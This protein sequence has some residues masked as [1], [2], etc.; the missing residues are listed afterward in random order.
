[1][2]V[3]MMAYVLSRLRN[4]AERGEMLRRSKTRGKR[5]SKVKK[6]PKLCSHTKEIEAPHVAQCAWDS[7]DKVLEK[8]MSETLDR[9]L[10]QHKSLDNEED[11][12]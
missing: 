5:R 6:H 4:R 9:D 7:N 8:C 2:M 1:M 11:I 10:R 12:D 3:T